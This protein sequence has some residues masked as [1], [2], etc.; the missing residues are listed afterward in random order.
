MHSFTPL[1]RR[2]LAFLSINITV[3]CNDGND[4][5]LTRDTPNVDI[6]YRGVNHL[7]NDYYYDY[8]GESSYSSKAYILYRTRIVLKIITNSIELYT[9]YL[10]TICILL[11]FII[12]NRERRRL[13]Y[14]LVPE[15]IR[16]YFTKILCC[17]C[18]RKSQITPLDD[19][20]IQGSSVQT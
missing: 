7:S 18:F 19:I 13:I 17:R 6:L 15:K 10:T 11:S 20:Q 4:I 2:D 16:N 1:K 3:W 5:C 14:Q 8:D 9:A 12:A